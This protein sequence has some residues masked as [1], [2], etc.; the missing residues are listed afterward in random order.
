M[1]SANF[2]SSLLPAA[3]YSWQPPFYSQLLWLKPFGLSIRV[4]HVVLAFLSSA[5]F[6]YYGDIQLYPCCCK[7]QHLTEF[8]CLKLCYSHRLSKNSPQKRAARGTGLWVQH[9]VVRIRRSAVSVSRVV[10][11]PQGY[12]HSSHRVLAWDWGQVW[13]FKL[14][15]RLK[16]NQKVLGQPHDVCAT[17]APVGV[18]C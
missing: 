2:S 18:S 9:E 16:F 13:V 5:Y 14:C 3:P 8:L 11:I 15:M 12:S 7:W 1:Y 10:A 4:N 6:I 17:I